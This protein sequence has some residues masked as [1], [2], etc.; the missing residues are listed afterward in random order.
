MCNEFKMSLI[1]LGQPN[2]TVFPQKSPRNVHFFE[3]NVFRA[4]RTRRSHGISEQMN[5]VTVL[6]TL[7]CLRRVHLV[8]NPPDASTL[9]WQ[10]NIWSTKHTRLGS[11]IVTSSPEISSFK[12][13]VTVARPHDIAPLPHYGLKGLFVPQATVLLSML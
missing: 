1:H 13:K 2:G 11:S 10:T 8:H 7:T 6:F 3:S 4:V 9:V 5:G 12:V